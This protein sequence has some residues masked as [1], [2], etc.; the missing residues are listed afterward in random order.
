MRRMHATTTLAAAL[1]LAAGARAD[2]AADKERQ[3]LAGTWKVVSA[4][5]NGQKVPAEL[6]GDFCFVITADKLTRKRGDRVESAAGYRLDPTKSPKWIDMTGQTDGKD[7]AI[8]ALYELDG[9]TLKLCVRNDYKTRDGKPRE[10]PVRP[11]K[12][13]GGAGTEQVLMLLRREKP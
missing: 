3:K 8:P 9:D 2:D 13:D 6:L 11:T 12:L 7:R 4:E 5:A 10:N 1:L